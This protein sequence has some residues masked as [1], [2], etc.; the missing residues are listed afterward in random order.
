MVRWTPPVGFYWWGIAVAVILIWSILE[1]VIDLPLI[2]MELEVWLVAM[3]I[4]AGVIYLLL[5]SG[6]GELFD[7]EMSRWA[8]EKEQVLIRLALAMRDF[9]AK[10]PIERRDKEVWF[11]LTPLNIVVA[12]G[13]ASIRVFVGP[14]NRETRTLVK[15]LESWVEHALA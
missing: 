12:E 4:I 11:L 10:P 8:M 13:A 1:V 6:L 14:S 3:V 9:G 5:R 7:Y 15:R 2:R